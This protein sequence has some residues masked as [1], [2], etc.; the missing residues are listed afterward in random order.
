[1]WCRSQ[2]AATREGIKAS[3]SASLAT[4]EGPEL[5]AYAVGLLSEYLTPN[6]QG[7]LAKRWRVGSAGANSTPAANAASQEVA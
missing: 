7:L 1:M 3:P 6:I 2:V 4:L 5:D